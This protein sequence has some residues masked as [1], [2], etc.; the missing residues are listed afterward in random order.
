VAAKTALNAKNLEALGAARLA[1]LLAEI[2]AGNAAAKRRLRLELAAA[3]SPGDVAKEVR[4][5]LTTIGGSRSFVDWQGVRS[6]ADDLDTQRR[7]IAETM[8]KSAPTEAL[9]LLWRFMALAPT[10]FRRVSPIAPT[11]LWWR[12][13]TASS[14][15]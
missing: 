13:A 2:S 14:T 8:A 6:L 11:K 1:E 10:V 12:T 4:K 3:Q 5:R 15:S 7:A 9:D